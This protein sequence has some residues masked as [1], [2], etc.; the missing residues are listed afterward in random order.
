MIYLAKYLNNFRHG[1]V[2]NPNFK[3]MSL[4]KYKHITNTSCVVVWYHLKKNKFYYLI[5]KRGLKMKR[6]GGNLAIGGGM[7]EDDRDMSLQYGAVREIMEESQIKFKNTKKLT[8]TKK[9]ISQLS[10]YLFFLSEDDT[11]VTFYM[12]LV[13]NKIPRWNGPILADKYPFKNSKWEIDMKDDTWNNKKLKGR[14]YKGHC[15]MTSD[16]IKKKYNK[17]PKMWNFSK[18]SLNKLFKILEN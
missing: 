15:L 3:P 5:Q 2:I 14:I 17:K 13:S 18:K 7:I 12:I 6:G 10:K 8:M 1:L 9:T 16:E 11:N 4:K